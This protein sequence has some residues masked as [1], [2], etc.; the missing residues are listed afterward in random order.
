[1]QVEIYGCREGD[2]KIFYKFVKNFTYPPFLSGILFG[3]FKK[4][5]RIQKSEVRSQNQGEKMN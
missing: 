4:E 3:D 5:V 1:M 2:L